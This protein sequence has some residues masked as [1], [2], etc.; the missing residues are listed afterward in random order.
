MKRAVKAISR[1]AGEFL[2]ALLI[3]TGWLPVV[4]VTL[5]A[6]DLNCQ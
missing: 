3:L 2:V 4:I 1:Y 5:A 6:C